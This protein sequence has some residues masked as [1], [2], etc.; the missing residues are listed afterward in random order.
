MVGLLNTLVGYSIFFVC[1]QIGLHYSIAIAT[2][3]LL[4]ALFNFKSIGVVVFRSN[5]NSK[6]IRFVIV[7]SLIYFINVAGMK[8][9]LEIGFQGWFAGL[10]LLLPLALISYILNSRYVFHH[11][12]KN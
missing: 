12:K 7:Y 10:L 3:T 1:L 6:L 8:V 9:L 11:E 2:A 5:D 4:G